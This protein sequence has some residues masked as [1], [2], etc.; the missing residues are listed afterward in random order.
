MAVPFPQFDL[1]HP[2]IH[3]LRVWLEAE[4]ERAR[5][6]LEGEKDTEE[7]RRIQ[8]RLALLKE[9]LRHTDPEQRPLQGVRSRFPSATRHPSTE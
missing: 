8:G 2:A 9:L 3:E 1:G 7:I 5:D 4:R 6:M